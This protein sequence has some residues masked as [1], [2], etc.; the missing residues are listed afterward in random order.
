MAAR[1]IAED[2]LEPINPKK[3]IPNYE[4]ID[5]TFRGMYY[6]PDEM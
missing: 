3:N 4:N 1:M 2:M 5:E 6:D